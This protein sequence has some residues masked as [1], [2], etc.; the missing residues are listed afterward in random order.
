[1]PISTSPPVAAA[2]SPPL[3]PASQ[4]R[5]KRRIVA[6]YKAIVR[7]HYAKR[8]GASVDRVLALAALQR[9]IQD[10]RLHRKVNSSELQP[11]VVLAKWNT[12]ALLKIW[13]KD[14]SGTVD[15]Q[16]WPQRLLLLLLLPTYP[17][18]WKRVDPVWLAFPCRDQLTCLGRFIQEFVDGLKYKYNKMQVAKPLKH[19]YR[20]R[21]PRPFSPDPSVHYSKNK[22]RRAGSSL[23]DD[24]Q[25]YPQHRP[26]SRTRT[27][28]TASQD[29]E[30][31]PSPTPHLMNDSM[32]FDAIDDIAA[33]MSALPH[34]LATSQSTDTQVPE[35]S[36]SEWQQRL[37]ELESE[38]DQHV[39][40]LQE[41]QETLANVE[42]EYEDQLNALH[43]RHRR[44]A[45]LNA[46][47][48]ARLQDAAEQAAA[49]PPSTCDVDVG[50]PELAAIHIDQATQVEPL[51]IERGS[52]A[53]ELA[54]P[55]EREAASS[56]VLATPATPTEAMSHS[57][58]A[59]QTDPVPVVETQLPEILGVESASDTQEVRTGSAIACQTDLHL[60]HMERLAAMSRVGANHLARIAERVD[61]G[62]QAAIESDVAMANTAIIYG[63]APDA[64]TSLA[65]IQS[66]A[67]PLRA[68]PEPG[69]PPVASLRPQL[70]AVPEHSN[71]ETGS[72]ET[73]EHWSHINAVLTHPS[74]LDEQEPT[75]PGTTP[76]PDSERVY[77]LVRR[78]RDLATPPANQRPQSMKTKISSPL[79]AAGPRASRRRRA[80]AQ[81]YE[82]ARRITVPRPAVDQS[83]A[84]G[85]QLEHFVEE[86]INV[87]V[88]QTRAGVSF[89]HRQTHVY[90]LACA[91]IFTGPGHS[92]L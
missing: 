58:A 71:S 18:Q 70:E 90:A 77:V 16:V 83:R 80:A 3:A 63:H 43:K 39:E 10:F 22:L 76:L 27:S 79:R 66:I 86:T 11:D 35:A 54:L 78:G 72:G 49:P 85:D 92:S 50:T 42:R 55:D 84:R 48:Q 12:Q 25:R 81:I 21:S 60:G 91:H 47:R 41:L 30:T 40:A 17:A 19:R 45:W 88:F 61:C 36:P 34:P 1:M 7:Y 46:A 37:A 74:T 89:S 87:P 4:R 64:D 32:D 28:R 2:A 31:P 53:L 51:T 52:S 82:A 33:P 67:P 75:V 69:E 59:V 29:P 23:S 14:K 8:S 13:D 68:L 9:A 65:Q 44:K 20:A 56:S 24:P 6:V 15:Y 62:V 5:Y 38:R 73:S 57:E 26:R